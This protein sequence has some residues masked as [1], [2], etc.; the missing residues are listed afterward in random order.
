MLA[1]LAILIAAG[2]ALAAAP[3]QQGATTE[4]G[5]CPARPG[6]GSYP[7][8]VKP[9]D[10][11]HAIRGNF[12][13]PRTSYRNGTPD[14]PASDPAGAFNLHNG[15]DIAAPDG[16]VVYPVVSGVVTHAD[17]EKVFVRAAGRR[18]FQYWHI[19]PSVRRGERVVASTT[20][21]GRV[22][23]GIGH[24]HLSE[25]DHWRIWNPATHLF[26]YSDSTPPT[27][28]RV[29]VRKGD[30][31]GTVA[32]TAEAYDAQNLPVAGG[33]HGLPVAPAEVEWT[34][35]TRSGAWILGPDVAVDFR[36][37]LPPPQ[38]F[39]LVYGGGTDHNHRGAAGRY[40]FNLTPGGF[41][42]RALWNG[43]YLV[44]VTA[45]D[46]CGNSTTVTEPLDVDNP[47]GKTLGTKRAR[48]P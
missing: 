17:R 13:D 6:P 20:I 38:A 45:T 2:T 29:D 35:L 26:P 10:R 15:V 5:S 28:A 3:A 18:T 43:H 41:D 22:L 9:F 16:T 11:P 37:T 47:G 23:P 32:L 7:W 42:T 24:V 21:L 34:L 44:A 46:V 30:R 31:P 19:A 36:R 27:I 14:E 48:R 12:G 33:W 1:K 40:V 25:I 4:R 8:P 39:W